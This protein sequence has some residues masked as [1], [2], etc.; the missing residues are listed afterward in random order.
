MNRTGRR[1]GREEPEYKEKRALRGRPR[2]V[3][4]KKVNDY[5]DVCASFQQMG[6]N[7]RGIR[8]FLSNLGGGK[9]M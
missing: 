3:D 5:R 6:T 2:R 8:G 7:M 9:A 4:G 1:D